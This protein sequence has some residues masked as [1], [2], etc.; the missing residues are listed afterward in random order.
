[1]IWRS[2]QPPPRRRDNAPSGEHFTLTAAKSRGWPGDY[3]D[4]NGCPGLATL[5]ILQKRE[6][7]P[8]LLGRLPAQG[9]RRRR[10]RW[11]AAS[12]WHECK[13]RCMNVH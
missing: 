7:L 9:R 2:R 12:L 4:I 6:G 10:R 1:M 5:A 8:A 3:Y 13:A 11:G